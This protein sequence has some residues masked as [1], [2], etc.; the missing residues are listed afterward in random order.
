MHKI[1]L[2]SKLILILGLF[3]ALMLLVLSHPSLSLADV[4]VRPILPGGSSI[5]PEDQTPIQM[6]GE[7]VTMN[8]RPATAADNAIIQINPNAYGLQIHP[9]WYPMV[10]EVQAVFTMT[11][12]TTEDVSL[13]AWFPLAS[14]LQNVSWELNP[15]EIV[16]R[17][18]SFQVAADGAPLD[19][20]VSELPNP[21]GTDKP[22]LPWASFPLTFPAGTDTNIQV[23]YLLPLQVSVKGS[24]LALYY[25]FQ[26]G[27]GWDGSIGKAELILDLPYPASAETLARMDPRTLGLPYF[28]ADP[29]T[30][31]PQDGV[32]VGNQ[33]HW[34][35]T[36]FEPGP[37]DDF[38]IWL[39]DPGL[40][41]QLESART[42]VQANPQDGQSWLNL[43]RL[44]RSLATGAWGYPSV[45]AESYLS[46]GLEAYRKAAQLLP[47][48]PEPHGGI[49]MLSLAPYMRDLNTPS[50][51]MG[52]VQEELRIARE[53]EAAH[54]NLA[55]QSEISSMIVDDALNNYFYKI[56]ATAIASA[57]SATSARQ[58]ENAAASPTP[59]DTPTPVST[60]TPV[61]GASYTP[62]PPPIT[63]TVLPSVQDAT[64][65]SAT[66]ETTSSTLPPGVVLLIEIVVFAVVGLL[67]YRF[68]LRKQGK[69]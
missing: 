6:A 8:V 27:A 26:T 67:V 38:S 14:A 35:W 45:F 33:A 24:E 34:T 13:N 54:P 11:N 64:S 17:I 25:I 3:L 36:D 69:P 52:L 46:Q 30:V 37:Q 31:L 58:T 42:A 57:T 18:L 60:V 5:L 20:S 21:K 22:P 39:V 59:T 68:L 63:P 50:E 15:D 12:P 47:E 65:T 4:G 62:Y 48:L 19:Y 16:P 7:V 40:Y 56:T 66:T 2:K 32:M 53:L 44:Y 49:A 51:V 55:E 10:A 29:E 41:Q 61:P 28:M 43:A 1:Q 9:V 23:N